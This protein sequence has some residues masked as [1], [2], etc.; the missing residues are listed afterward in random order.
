MAKTIY[1]TDIGVIKTYKNHVFFKVMDVQEAHDEK[2]MYSVLNNIVDEVKNLHKRY[3]KADK[4][5]QIVLIFDL[6]D[7][8]NMKVSMVFPLM[9]WL[10]QT[11]PFFSQALNYSHIVGINMIWKT[12]LQ[13]L[14]KLIS[15]ARP[16]HIEKCPQ[17]VLD[18]FK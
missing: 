6:K 11:K 12:V 13:M 5:N 4:S 15:T 16:I 14:D 2:V 17:T 3:I 9:R 10:R 1:E 8:S 7:S 18:L